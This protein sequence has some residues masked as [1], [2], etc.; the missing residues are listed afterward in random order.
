[1][2]VPTSISSFINNDSR[3]LFATKGFYRTII[4]LVKPWFY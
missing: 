4:A 2:H 1:M 3:I